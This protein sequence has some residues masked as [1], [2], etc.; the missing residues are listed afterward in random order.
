[1]CGCA[2]AKVGRGWTR[3]LSDGHGRGRRRPTLEHGGGDL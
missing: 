3:G 1:M 2:T